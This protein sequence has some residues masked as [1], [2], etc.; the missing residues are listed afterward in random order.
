MANQEVNPRITSVLWLGSLQDAGW[1]RVPARL[2]LWLVETKQKIQG[3]QTSEISE[4][5]T[6]AIL[7][8]FWG[9]AQGPLK[10]SAE[11]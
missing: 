5:S 1:G 6:R 11:H 7:K 10:H 4:K 2:P 3:D 8:E 9:S